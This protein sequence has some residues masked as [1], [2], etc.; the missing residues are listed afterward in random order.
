M[1]RVLIVKRGE[2][3]AHLGLA[4]ALG[5]PQVCEGIPPRYADAV[6][7]LPSVVVE[8][9][10]RPGDILAVLAGPALTLENVEAVVDLPAPPP[11][12]D[13]W[14]ELAALTERVE[15][16]ESEKQIQP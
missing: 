8:S 1:R 9:A 12:R 14:E 5:V 3:E 16:L 11:P 6:T 7:E 2:L 13:I 10:N 4:S 15:T